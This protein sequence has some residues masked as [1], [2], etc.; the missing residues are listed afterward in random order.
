M[1]KRHF[2]RL[3]AFALAA[4]LSVITAAV[5]FGDAFPITSSITASAAEHV[6]G[7]DTLKIGGISVVN[8]GYTDVT[9]GS[10][11]KYDPISNTL[12]IDGE[13][14]HDDTAGSRGAYIYV[15]GNLT[16]KV[17]GNSKITSVTDS[18][19]I[20][21]DYGE[22]DLIIDECFS[23]TFLLSGND[24]FEGC[25]GAI[26]ANK[27][28]GPSGLVK[29][30]GK[31]IECEEYNATFGGHTCE[32]GK[33]TKC[34]A[35]EITS[36]N[37]PDGNFR[38]YI[39]YTLTDIAGN[40]VGGDGI[41]TAKEIA[42]VKEIN[43]KN[44][45]ISSLKGIEYFTSITSLEC[46]DNN[47]TEL[48][49][50]KNTELTT[51]E[52]SYNQLT[53]LDVSQ[54]TKLKELDCY[55]NNLTELDVSR[56][57]ELT[58]L[59]C[60]NN[61]LTSL[62]VSKNTKLTILTCNY[63]RLTKLDVINNTEL[64]ELY[65]DTNSL[66]ALD[67]SSSDKLLI[68]DFTD[69]QVSELKLSEN[70]SK[71]NQ[72]GCANN[73]LTELDLS[74]IEFVYNDNGSSNAQT[75][76]KC[77]NNE[78]TNIK[79]KDDAKIFFFYADNNPLLAINGGSSEDFCFADD[80]YFR[81]SPLKDFIT[82]NKTIILADYGINPDQV[83]NLSNAEISDDKTK[84]EITDFPATYDYGFADGK[85]IS[86]TISYGIPIDKEHFPDDNFRN[87]ILKRDYGTDGVLTADEIASVEKIDVTNKFISDLTG[88]EYFTELKTLNCSENQL[89]SLDLSK[90]T[91]L[92]KLY[93]QGCF[94]TSLNVSNNTKLTKLD[95]S[96][97][98]LTKLDLSKN[99]LL[100]EL[101]CK[102]NQLTKLDLSKNTLLTE[103]LCSS[104]PLTSLDLSAT[105][106]TNLF[107]YVD[108]E[109]YAYKTVFDGGKLDLT[110]LEGF[111]VSKASQW[112]N[113]TIEGNIISIIDPTKYVRYIYDTGK[114]DA[115]FMIVAE[116][117]SLTADMIEVED[118]TYT[119]EKIEPKPVVKCGDY[120][121]VEGTDYTLSYD[122]NT[123]AGTGK[124]IVTAK[125][126]F[127]T[128]S[129]EAEFKINKAA[130]AE[131]TPPTASGL[132]YGQ[133]LS[134]SVLSDEN[135]SWVDDTVIPTVNND[136]YEAS[137]PVDDK[138]YDYS[139]DKG[140]NEEDHTVTRTI[141]VT[142]KKAAP[143]EI[144]LPTASG[145]T[146]GQKLSE[147]VLS[148]ENWKWVDG[149]V[150]PTVNNDGY[151]ASIIVDDKNY[152]YSDV[153]GYNE[154]DHTVTRTIEVTVKKATPAEIILPTASGL[155]YGQ[156]LSES[157]LSDENWKWVDGKV[158]P[159]VNNDGYE[160]SIIVDDKNYD[161]SDVEGYNEKDHTV[162]RTIEVTVS[163]AEPK[164]I[165]L[166]TASGLTY[167]QK[168]SESILSDE[169][170]KWVD[171]KVIPTVNND[172]YEASI[173]VDDKNYDYS[174]DKG[175]NEK[176]HT[177]TRTIEVTV[178]K[179]TPAEIIPPTA[180]GLTYGQKLSESVLSDENWKWVDGKVI[181][182]VNNDGY[183]ASIIVDDKNYDYSD[184]EGYNEKDHTVTRTIEVTV[185]KAEPKEIVL[186][187]ASGLT[188]GQ[189]LSESILSDENW[190][191]VD[192]KVIPT[193]NN[194][195]YEASIIVDDKNYDYSADKGYNEKDHTVTRTIEVTVKKATPAE[196]I[197]PTASGLTYG[198]K[199]SESVLS[200]ENWKWVDG[201]VIPTV[202][203]DGY[204]ASII[205]DDKNYDYSADK[206]YNEKDHTVTRTIEVT[207]EKADPTVNPVIDDADYE[208]GDDLPEIRLSENDTLGKVEWIEKIAKLVEGKNILD[209]KFTPEDENYNDVTGTL[210][211]NAKATTTTTTTV[212]T[213]TTAVST[214]K[215][216]VA[217]TT[218]PTTTVSTT[219][220]TTASTTK[221]TT[222][223]TTK[224]TTASA[225]KPTTTVST[226]KATTASTTGTTAV[227]T[228]KATVA[229][230]T[231][232]ITT[233]STTKAT[234]ANTTKPTTI[235]TTKATTAST[236]GTTTVSTTKATT[237][238][239]TG[240]TAVSTTK[241]TVAS[242]T[243]PI[244][245][246]STTKA[247]TA[248]TTKPT[249]ISTTKATTASTTGTTTVSTTKAT[250]ASTTGTTAVSTTKAT[251][252]STTKPITTVSTTKA[253]T[254]NTTKATTVST[255]KATTA[256]TTKA[257]TVSTT[258]ATTA[259]TT[260]A[261]TVST[262]KATTANTT[263]PTTVS[264]TKATTANT[265]KA[266]TVSTTK[267]TTANTTK[268]T[269]VSTTKATTANTTKPTTAVSTTKATVASTTGTTVSSSTS[270]STPV[271]TTAISTTSTPTTTTVPPT[272]TP[273]VTEVLGDA[274]DDGK[275]DVRDAA[276]IARMLA[277]RD[278]EKLPAKAD[279]NGD[280]KTD[281][282]DAA[283]IARFLAKN[284]KK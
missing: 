225:T 160:A 103:L 12:Y 71:L 7:L 46:Y 166:P 85:T 277:Q 203:N 33:C 211:V 135:W 220:A 4:A 113:A 208:D 229:S 178:K 265:T 104:N 228:T 167:G 144:I 56:N 17:T 257:T 216:T 80:Y 22:V 260:K 184:V 224:A 173:I 253:T 177:V 27:L 83:S 276:H 110:T 170:W 126:D 8:D 241:A 226:T 176:D 91:A 154:K 99:T 40:K 221:P 266:T 230:T 163:K 235:S 127:Y 181:P 123:E 132:T 180:S 250:T 2:T 18:V 164:E 140:Y 147:S 119:G 194:D 213:T 242:T 262:T 38:D 261:T 210:I 3:S 279:F 202:N 232:P 159:T 70:L 59:V 125:G 62:D 32:N 162:T 60:S 30:N 82:E 142:V 105:A 24:M 187:T 68:L 134:E 204:E 95:C 234:T 146:Y 283:A 5:P 131:I 90:N 223:S 281:V 152:D 212:A 183:E 120:T 155:T 168:L 106:V 174:A 274:N 275:L 149:K 88:I 247:T 172:G 273:Q 28:F 26:A 94:T 188:Y 76:L 102:A 192:G 67:L 29:M 139:A 20:Y 145:L 47:L 43:V 259:N 117:V 66:T 73:K 109:E 44:K 74:N 179:A 245:T 108:S 256:N 55:D 150:I 54:N 112:S 101:D 237:A 252:A 122:K 137:I 15:E 81:V 195:G 191:W 138:N 61:Q 151:E 41:L 93:C 196:I 193:V 209:W 107:A 49:V 244:T 79:L 258:K 255:T 9:L 129:A 200:D 161:Y 218:K 248:N 6:D 35:F 153:E 243:K 1:K 240:T 206:G 77:S 254:A 233:V 201:K 96:Y 128:G 100:T 284:H 171:G 207:V 130:P 249:T 263:K 37:F 89:T 219:K 141:E 267:A 98:R 236:T 118:Q 231:K 271:S 278:T 205:V 23:L 78:I 251:V 222:V 97:N 189:K 264:T 215:A 75:E 19:G 65:C 25:R 246:V 136:G 53:S 45:N 36:E 124:V 158:I 52:C 16:I 238:S 133:K 116:S 10:N 182:T 57:T 272:T 87:W 114:G 92:T 86:C 186:P 13:N 34:G 63:N 21:S 217:S 270:T 282:R 64:E 48:D 143:A 111:D 197:P 175:Y 227:S 156:K 157:V 165:V 269:T 185:S 42:A 199:L 190:K 11:W 39:L 14:S 50:S 115:I 214:T 69:N 280:G 51:L 31:E 58:T 84:L 198:Q 239:T 268:P 148:D 169:N 121:L 72:L